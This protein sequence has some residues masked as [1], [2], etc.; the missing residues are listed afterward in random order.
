MPFLQILEEETFRWQY[1]DPETNEQFGTIFLLREVPESVA[2][3]LQRQHTKRKF[4]R[5]VP[6]EDVDFRAFTNDVL[7]YAVR[8]WEKLFST[9]QTEIVFTEETKASTLPKL[10][11]KVKAAIVK[12]VLGREAGL[13][14][15]AEADAASD[16]EGSEGDGASPTQPAGS[17]S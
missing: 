4:T 16:G 6:Q 17:K 12:I 14:L 9:K 10:P 2:K 3:N 15:G 7:A 11:E 13:Y 1:R 8:G 5:G